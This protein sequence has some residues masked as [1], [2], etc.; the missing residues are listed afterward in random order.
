MESEKS[1]PPPNERDNVSPLE[2]R[3]LKVAELILGPLD[4]NLEGTAYFITCPGEHLHTTRDG[5]RDCILYLDG[6][7]IHCFHSSCQ[8]ARITATRQL[9]TA[10]L[11][12]GLS[13]PKPKPS[14]RTLALRELRKNI[15]DLRPLILKAYAWPVEEIATASPECI[16]AEPT[17][18]GHLMLNLFE[19]EAVIW[20]GDLN[21]TGSPR[22]RANFK[23]ASEWREASDL[24]GPYI[25]PGEFAPGTF[26]R[27]KDKVLQT[28]FHVIEGDSLIGFIPKT[29]EEKK[30]NK[31]ACGAVFRWLRED[32]GFKLRA[33][34]DAANK[35][36]HGWFDYP[37]HLE[38]DELRAILN[39]IGCDDSL[40]NPA[41]PV[42]LPGVKRGDA[43]QKLLY[44]RT[45]P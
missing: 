33:A 3:A 12:E 8:A 42:R 25:C 45:T 1:V 27:T 41:Q 16:P 14:P 40:M 23:T 39:G 6:P 29:P 28:K 34:V 32:F 35:S 22:F 21:S 24:V 5:A 19:P 9:Q 10:L 15:S 13:L 36:L 26:C 38:S 30:A 37:S 43:F 2:S 7:R 44:W 18:H 11:A 31:D 4:S 20:I 17:V